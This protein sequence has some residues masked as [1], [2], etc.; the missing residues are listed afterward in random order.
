MDALY[1]I[2]IPL[3]RFLFLDWVVRRSLD[4]QESPEYF[5]QNGVIIK[6]VEALDATGEV[7][8]S[9]LGAPIFGRVDFK[10]MV[11]EFAGVVPATY[12]TRIAENELFLDPGLLYVTRPGTVRPDSPHA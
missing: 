10:G 1:I 4:R 11:Y 7:I 5:R 2:L 8:G 6:R 12:R 3:A 9:Y